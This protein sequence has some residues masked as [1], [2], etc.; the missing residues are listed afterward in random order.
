VLGRI[1]F[2]R[3]IKVTEESQISSC[4]SADPALLLRGLRRLAPLVREVDWRGTGSAA[5]ESKDGA[6]LRDALT[7]A[8]W[9]Q[10]RVL[11]LKG[12]CLDA[13]LLQA[14]FSRGPTIGSGPFPQLE[15]LRIRPAGQTSIY[16]RA[17]GGRGVS[18]EAGAPLIETIAKACPDLRVLDVVLRGHPFHGGVPPAVAALWQL[19]ELTV[20]GNLSLRWSSA[21][22]QNLRH[23]KRLNFFG[24]V[25]YMYMACELPIISPTV[26]QLALE[27][28]A[29]AECGRQPVGGLLE[30]LP[31]LRALHITLQRHSILLPLTLRDIRLRNL[32]CVRT[33]VS[34]LE[35]KEEQHLAG[36]KELQSELGVPSSAGRAAGTEGR[37]AVKVTMEELPADCSLVKSFPCKSA[38][39]PPAEREHATTQ[40]G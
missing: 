28:V 15:E 6:F 27:E 25:G 40:V 29:L 10:L 26:T 39:Q 2:R 33:I 34:S 17:S 4:T 12:C 7:G 38:N 30:G 23:L 37:A 21:A 16:D 18:E 19:R 14:V 22:L 5:A 20:F 3:A 8:R 36:L 9:Q 24:D 11:Q 35:S 1:E 13:S 32:A 31:R